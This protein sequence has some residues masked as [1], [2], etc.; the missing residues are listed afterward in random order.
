MKTVR[1]RKDVK[2]KL[3]LFGDGKSNN[4]AMRELLEDADTFDEVIEVTGKEYYN[5]K[6]DDDLLQKLDDCKKYSNESRS[7]IVL[8]LL[9]SRMNQP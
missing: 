5:I 7:D 8:R 4:K 3:D 9:E 1:L 2:E 6:I